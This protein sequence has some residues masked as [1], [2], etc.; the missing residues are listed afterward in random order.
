[1]N[2]QIDEDTAGSL[3]L[4]EDQLR[5]ELAVGLF[6]DNKLSLGRAARVAGMDSIQF[7]RE[8]AARRIPLHYGVEEFRQ[9]LRTIESLSAH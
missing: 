1:M 2:I 8:L 7:Q 4:T 5:F 3:N 6:V 9:D